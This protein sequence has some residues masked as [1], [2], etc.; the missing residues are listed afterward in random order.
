MNDFKIVGGFVSIKLTQGKR[1]VID[2]ADWAVVREYQWRAE[3]RERTFYVATTI[4]RDGKKTTLRLHTLVSGLKGVDHEDG[5]G[6]NN[7]RSNLRAA[8]PVQQSRNCRK[9]RSSIFKGVTWHRK[10]R[11]YQAR[12]RS[13]P[14]L[15]THLGLFDT[16]IA[17]ARAYDSAAR[18]Y[19]GKFASPNFK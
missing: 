15:T 6:L 5:D 8:S 12:I 19:H 16:A 7:R 4:Y 18:R 10:A 17:A 14:Y 3:K 11:K 1:T 9:N 13:E 2:A